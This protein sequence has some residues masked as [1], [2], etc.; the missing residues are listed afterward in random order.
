MAHPKAA[1]KAT[2]ESSSKRFWARPAV[3]N[4]LM[5]R[6]PAKLSCIVEV[7]SDAA[8]RYTSV[9]VRMRGMAHCAQISAGTTSTAAA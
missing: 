5:R 8:A 6:M 7:T 2:T 3:P 4:A 9:R 1:L